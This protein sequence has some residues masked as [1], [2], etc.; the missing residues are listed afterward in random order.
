MQRKKP[1][2]AR[3]ITSVLR[4]TTLPI[5]EA[6]LLLAHLFQTTREHIIAHRETPVSFITYLRFL[7]LSVKRKNHVPLAYLTREKEFY[8]LLFRVSKH[9]LVPRPETEYLVEQARKELQSMHQVMLIDVGT[10]TGCIP[11]AIAKYHSIKACIALDISSQALRVAKHNF[12]KHG[13][14]GMCIKSSLLTSP[15]LT[16]HI[17][18]HTGDIL[19]TANLPYLPLKDWREEPSI[20]REPKIALVSGEDGLDLYRLFVAQLTNHPVMRTRSYRVICE[21]LA[22]QVTTCIDILTKE[23]PHATHEVTYDSCGL[24]AFITIR[25]ETP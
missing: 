15:L 22:S 16:K 23:L 3:N 18:K 20:S 7:R 6:E 2:K 1:L 4:K 25:H 5:F 9:T 12:T 11:I 17:E 21:M 19:I 10:G 14:P 13:V 24:I 8:G